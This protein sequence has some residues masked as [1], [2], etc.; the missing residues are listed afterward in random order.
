MADFGRSVEQ[1]LTS[2]TLNVKL[3]NGFSVLDPYQSTD[4]RSVIHQFCTT[5]YTGSHKRLSVWG[6]NPGRFGAG[7]T[8][9]SFTDP[10]A[11]T[12]QLGMNTEIIGRREPSAE[13]ISSVIDGYGGPR[14]FYRDMFM[15]A[16]SPLGFIKDGKN[17]NF[18]DDASLK[19][20][21][22]PFVLTSMRTMIDAGLRTEATVLLG[23]GALQAF[24]KKFIAPEI[25]FDTVV[26]L[27]HPRYIMQ[28]RRREMERY[29]LQYVDTLKTLCEASNS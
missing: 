18:Y 14:A 27:D 2:L 17:I 16:L 4:V 13:F 10:Y 5:Y 7:V 26:Y 6:I 9:L 23:S 20:D 15:S 1:F 19:K 12:Q 8:G 22:V 25:I 29:V 11:L 24:F 21:I 28:Y 3:P